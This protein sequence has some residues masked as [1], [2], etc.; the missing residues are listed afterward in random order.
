M[1]EH[2][3]PVGYTL[4]AYGVSDRDGCGA[5]HPQAASG[6]AL[7]AVTEAAIGRKTCALPARYALQACGVSYREGT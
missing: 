1:T 6:G 5:H 7:A 2:L 4:H 3:L